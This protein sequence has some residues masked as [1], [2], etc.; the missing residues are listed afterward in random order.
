[1]SVL[2]VL[3]D[4]KK[5]INFDS[6]DEK[7]FLALDQANLEMHFIRYVVWSKYIEFLYYFSPLFPIIFNLSLFTIV[8]NLFVK[9]FEFQKTYLVLLLCIPSLFLFSQTIL[10]DCFLLTLN[11]IL[12]LRIN[13]KN[14]I[15]SIGIIVFL[16]SMLRPLF[17]VILFFS[18]ISSFLIEKVK[19]SLSYVFLGQIIILF[20]LLSFPTLKEMFFIEYYKLNVDDVFSLFQIDLFN[21]QDFQLAIGVF[22]NWLLYY[23]GINLSMNNVLLLF[24]FIFESIIY[25][26]FF[27]SFIFFNKIKYKEDYLYR[28]SFWLIIFSIL[29]AVLEADWASMYR[30]KL[31]FLPALLYFVSFKNN[32][33]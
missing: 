20:V 26:I 24:P 15:K 1:M 19:F 25:F 5:F 30:H 21:V 27:S 7:L 23:F 32:K 14:N 11:M 17:G 16:I 2:F 4:F 12:Y 9:K 6:P 10:R 28:F 3:L 22:F 8:L 33:Q 31:F 13:Q 29:S 18:F